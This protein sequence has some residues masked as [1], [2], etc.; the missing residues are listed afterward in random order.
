MDTAI[1]SSF[2]VLTWNTL[3][4][5]Y[6]ESTQEHSK[7]P[8]YGET[9]EAIHHEKNRNPR[10]VNFLAWARADIMLLQ[11]VSLP[12][13]ELLVTE[14]DDRYAFEHQN[15]SNKSF[16]DNVSIVY[17][18]D[19]FHA[20][21]PSH[22]VF[23]PEDGEEA[24][25]NSANVLRLVHKAS[26]FSFMVASV[27]L[28]GFPIGQHVRLRGVKTVADATAGPIIIGG[29]YNTDVPHPG[30]LHEYAMDL[31]SN[32]STEA[33]DHRATLD[34]KEHNPRAEAMRI[35]GPFIDCA[36]MEAKSS[37]TFCTQ[38]IKPK[39]TDRIWARGFASADRVL[40]PFDGLP[41]HPLP[42]IAVPSDHLPVMSRVSFSF[43][44][45]K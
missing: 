40:T 39:A 4:Q 30:G 16:P 1:E 44:P 18:K 37:W 3:L 34:G 31:L 17:N 32:G 25:K 28:D 29:D 45:P 35:R 19:V 2:T 13:V 41:P 42:S 36:P 10:I 22:Q 21:G 7:P 14:F 12:L 20:H 6:F 33:F 38:E 23:N 26:G 9:N 27:H 43:P 5:R 8:S 11:E 24:C 15:R